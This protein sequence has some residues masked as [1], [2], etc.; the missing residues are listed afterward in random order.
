MEPFLHLDSLSI[1]H[2]HK[3]EFVTNGFNPSVVSL[4]FTLTIKLPTSILAIK[5]T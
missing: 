5:R 2:A 3:L 4:S 1:I